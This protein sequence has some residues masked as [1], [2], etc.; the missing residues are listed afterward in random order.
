[1]DSGLIEELS[2]QMYCMIYLKKIN[3][4]IYYIRQSSISA[5]NCGTDREVCYITYAHCGG[6][7]DCVR[8]C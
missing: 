6:R 2:S 8:Y 7:Y 1:M 5:E 3:M 4:L